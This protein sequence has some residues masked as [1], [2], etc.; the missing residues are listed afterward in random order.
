MSSDN[1]KVKTA[2][3]KKKKIVDIKNVDSL[4]VFTVIPIETPVKIPVEKKVIKKTIKK[5]VKE[6][7]INVDEK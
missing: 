5:I 7:N 4:E 6:K 3:V 1:I 2:T